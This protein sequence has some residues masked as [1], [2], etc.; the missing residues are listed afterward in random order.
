M[1]NIAHQ[2]IC[3]VFRS[4]NIPTMHQVMRVDLRFLRT[5]GPESVVAKTLAWLLFNVFAFV[6]VFMSRKEVLAVQYE[7]I[8]SFPSAFLAKFFCRCPCIGDDVIIP[9]SSRL[10]ALLAFVV[11]STSDCVLSSME[12]T[13]LRRLRPGRVLHVPSGI[14]KYF[15]LKRPS[16]SFA[17]TRAVFT[18]PLSYR[19]NRS[20][21]RH[22]V[23]LSSKMPKGSETEFLIVGGPV[24]KE[25]SSSEKVRFMGELDDISLLRVYRDANV[26]TLPFFGI[27]SEGP[28][29]KVL[30]YMAAQLLV[31]SS[32]EGIQG[33]HDFVAW[34]HYVPV[35]SLEGMKEALMSVRRAPELY[36]EIAR[37]GHRFAMAHYKWPDLLK[38]YLSFVEGFDSLLHS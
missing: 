17:R 38:Q 7:S 37:R 32:P 12:F 18:G 29:V 3:P 15:V 10:S 26:G 23:Q 2:V 5:L 25:F 9:G 36:A 27:P 1:A 8:F 19:A 22:L 30:E 14:D 31:I 11:A 20:A 13:I 34:Q 6:K 35:S 28:K 16:M 24:P 4:K 21:V 33:Y